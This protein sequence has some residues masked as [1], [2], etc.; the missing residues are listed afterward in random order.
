MPRLPQ[1]RGCLNAIYVPACLYTIGN[2]TQ[3][4]VTIVK[5]VRGLWLCLKGINASLV[6]GKSM[7]DG[8]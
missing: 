6:R 5:H 8:D 4:E 3:L 2:H 1:C 7:V